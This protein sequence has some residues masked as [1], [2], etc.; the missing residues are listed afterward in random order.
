MYS[1]ATTLKENRQYITN[2]KFRDVGAW[3]HVVAAMDT[4]QGT[5]SNRL[6]MYVNGVL[7]T[8]FDTEDYPAEDAD[9]YVNVDGY[10]HYIGTEQ[11]GRYA[12]MYMAEERLGERI[13]DSYLWKTLI[14]N[15]ILLIG[16]SDF[17]VEDS[18]P[19]MGIYAAVNRTKFDDTPSGGW[20]PKELLNLKEALEIYTKNTAYGSFKENVKGNIEIGKIADFTLIDRNIITLPNVD[21][22]K[23]KISA[24]IVNGEMVYKD[25]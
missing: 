12:D 18:S 20:Q 11:S 8:E 24:T 23:C 25:F 22:L 15:N 19:L 1:R 16:G 10:N 21:I 9:L 17:P 7:M 5:A 4:T 3:Y 2:R 6:K 14:N 13:E